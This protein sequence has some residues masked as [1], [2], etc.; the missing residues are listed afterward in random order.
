MKKYIFLFIACMC[1]MQVIAGSVSKRYTTFLTESGMLYFIKP[2]HMP[3]CN[4]NQTKYGMTFDIT[5]LSGDKDSVIFTTTVV[6]PFMEKLDSVFIKNESKI[7]KVKTELI[8]CEP[9]K[10][11]YVNRLRFY[12]KWSEWKEFYSC[13][14]PYVIEFGNYLCFSFHQNKWKEESKT[15][16]DIINI[17]ELSK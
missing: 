9:Y 13:M 1:C 8:Y 14:T 11:Y 16:N 15:I 2:M 3:K 12:I 10:S 4:G 7:V 5:Y 6:T 17:I